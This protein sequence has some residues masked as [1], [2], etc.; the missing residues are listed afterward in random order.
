MKKITLHI[1]GTHCKAC[2]I[3]VEDALGEIPEIRSA[4]VDL[5]KKTVTI[6]TT[7]EKNDGELALEW[8]NRV[9][10]SGYS[11][12]SEPPSRGNRFS[13]L[14]GGVFLGITLLVLFFLLQKSGMVRVG[15]G[16][17]FTPFT[18]FFIGIVA[19]V[20]SCL[21]IVGGLVLSLSAK[22][23]QHESSWKPIALFHIGRIAGFAVLGGVLGFAGS[24][25]AIRHEVSALLGIAVSIIMILLG[26]NL[27]DIFHVTK[28]WQ[29]TLGRGL[30]DRFTRFEKGVTA[31]AL[32][33]MGTFFLPCGFTQSM[34]F[35]ALSSASVL[36][37]FLIML[38]FALGTFPVLLALSWG[39]L[40]FSA[41]PYAPVFFKTAGTVV[42]G[43]GLFSF[44]SGLAGLGVIR[45]FF[46]L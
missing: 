26:I 6:E 16:E 13:G 33:G 17:T 11:I 8:S 12:S 46:I 38:F 32:V 21:A 5:G 43:L 36:Q 24:A 22:V 44:L 10:P 40:T 42:I 14:F 39:S 41:S 30:F 35:A 4:S 20:S 45:P 9:E 3:L 2:K 28:Q 37:G 25:V 27:L 23:S 34:Q 1:E 7:S 15:F 18:A 29:P 19:S 31:P